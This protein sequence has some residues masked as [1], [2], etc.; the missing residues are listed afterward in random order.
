MEDVLQ[1]VGRLLERY[2]QSGTHILSKPLILHRSNSISAI[3]KKMNNQK[4]EG[5]MDRP[6]YRD[7]W[8]HLKIKGEKKYEFRGRKNAQSTD[9]LTDGP[10]DWPTN[11]PMDGQTLFATKN[12]R[13]EKT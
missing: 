13:R 4:M 1:V 2:L 5:R 10:T 6:L 8:I 11:Q 9:V 12:K 3:W 7:A